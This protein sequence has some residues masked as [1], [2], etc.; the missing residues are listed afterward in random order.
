MSAHFRQA[1]LHPTAERICHDALSFKGLDIRS[2]PLTFRLLPASSARLPSL[3]WRRST[4]DN[5]DFKIARM[6]VRML[7][8]KLGIRPWPLACPRSRSNGKSTAPS[9]DRA[10]RSSGSLKHPMRRQRWKRQSKNS[11]SS[12]LSTR[13]DSLCGSCP[14]TTN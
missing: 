7:G 8:R 13:T 4:R 10:A 1:I 14:A 9:R 3:A 2:R 6:R 5:L 11:G 12:I